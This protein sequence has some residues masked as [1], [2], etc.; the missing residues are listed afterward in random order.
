MWPESL[1]T[2]LS[3]LVRQILDELANSLF[4]LYEP[5]NRCPILR[6]LRV[7]WVKDNRY[8]G[9]MARFCQG[10]EKEKKRYMYACMH[11]CTCVY[12]WLLA[13]CFWKACWPLVRKKTGERVISQLPAFC[14][15]S[16]LFPFKWLE[17]T[18]DI[19]FGWQSHLIYS[20]YLHWQCPAFHH[21]A[22]TSLS[23]FLAKQVVQSILHCVVVGCLFQ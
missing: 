11:V 12:I 9:K 14:R 3:W 6:V 2:C 7:Q 13:Y 18:T 4:K 23:F 20:T 1:L 5:L 16:W 15:F 17:L 19:I 10:V 22:D 21:I 8:K